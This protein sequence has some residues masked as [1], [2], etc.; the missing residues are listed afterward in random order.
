MRIVAEA[1]AIKGL[2][3]EQEKPANTKYKQ[4]ER[5]A[6][7]AKSFEL[8]SDLALLYMQELDKQQTTVASNPGNYKTYLKIITI[9]FQFLSI[10]S[11]YYHYHT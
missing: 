8:A 4:A 11:I 7:M 6:D 10:I 9:V 2:C 5:D 3:L 1:Y